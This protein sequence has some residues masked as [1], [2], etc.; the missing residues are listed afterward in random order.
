MAVGPSFDVVVVG[1]GHAG[2]Q[3]AITLRQ[4]KFTG[5]ILILGD[6]P[7]P[8]YERPALSKE[9]LSG[10]KTFD[11]IMLRPL[12]FWASRQ[13]NLGLGRR[14]VGV[15]PVARTVAIQDG[16]TFGY[17]VLVWAGGGRAR[18][19]DCEGHSLSGVHTVRT[20]ADVDRMMQ[21]LDTTAN[22]V[23]VGGGFIGLEAAA[24]LIKHGKRVT[25]LEA[26]DRI[27][28]RASSAPISHFY[29]AEHRAHGVDVRLGAQVASIEGTE[30]R[31]TAVRLATG[32]QVPAD[33]VIVG[34][35]IIPAVEPLL[36]AG[37]TGEIG[38]DV[39]VSCRTDLPDIYAIGDCANHDNPFGPGGRVRL[40]SIQNANDQAGV[41]ARAIMGEAATY[42]AAPWFWSNQYDLR[43]QTV[44]LS[45]GHDEVIVRKGESDRSFSIVY[46]RSGRVIA[47]DCVN[48][49]RDYVQ[50]RHLVVARARPDKN[51]L[52]DASVQIKDLQGPDA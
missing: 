25:V 45:A 28:A 19:L 40:E 4:R 42:D 22:V 26:A 27:L 14:V 20:R 43:L 32:E 24:A 48:A 12:D 49:T 30:G 8:P 47:L 9:Y 29:E 39:D 13:I 18:P 15:D 5:T 50:G 10:E 23:I 3:V 52:A 41:A 33:M 21:E 51:R 37:A 1:A 36:A 31:V 11:R 38:V 46:L 35:G 16:G 17:G 6:E 44:G 2:A 34:I 7:D